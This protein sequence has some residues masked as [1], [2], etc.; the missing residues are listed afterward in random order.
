MLRITIFLSMCL[1]CMHANSK[2]HYM[3][4]R[5]TWSAALIIKTLIEN[6]QLCQ[7]RVQSAARDKKI[8]P[9]YWIKNK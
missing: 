1:F 5:I 8:L 2:Y 9:S 4:T 6:S 3:Q 7:P